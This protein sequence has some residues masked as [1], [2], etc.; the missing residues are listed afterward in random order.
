MKQSLVVEVK[1]KESNPNSECDPENI[2]NKKIND[3]DPTA[4][5]ANSTIQPEEPVYL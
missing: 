1:D 5:V 2:Q 4:T 3:T